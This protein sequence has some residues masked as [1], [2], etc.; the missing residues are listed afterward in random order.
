[1]RLWI[2]TYVA[3]ALGFLGCDAVWLSLM[4]SRLYRPALGGLLR[5]PFAPAPA[6]AF[7]AI[8]IAGILIF[9]VAPARAAGDWTGATWRG[10]LLGLMAY[11]TYDLTNQATLRD[12]PLAITLA[13]LCWGTALTAKA[14]TI[15]FIAARW[16]G[17][18]ASTG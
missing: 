8:Y 18:S 1:M 12:W 13:D 16:A 7:Y 9:A 15:G 3:T 2:V 17:G 11:A 6:I 5:E 14:A 4:A 10:A